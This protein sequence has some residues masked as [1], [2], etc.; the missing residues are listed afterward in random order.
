MVL[1]RFPLTQVKF[2]DGPHLARV[3]VNVPTTRFMKRL[4]NMEEAY[5]RKMALPD[6]LIILRVNPEIAVQRKTDETE[7]SVRAR[8]TE[9]WELNWEQTNAYV[10]DANRPKE[11]VLKDV[12]QVIWSHL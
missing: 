6:L 5:Y 12:K 8:S 7:E 9:I 4:I 2:M 1:D 10:I 3:T 11:E